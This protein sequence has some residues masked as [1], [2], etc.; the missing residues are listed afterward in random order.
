MTEIFRLK[1]TADNYEHAGVVPEFLDE[2]PTEKNAEQAANANI[3]VR[4]LKMKGK[5]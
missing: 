5:E 2:D 1:K 3:E 4:S